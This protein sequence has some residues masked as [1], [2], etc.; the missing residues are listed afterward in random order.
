MTT[1]YTFIVGTI[2]AVLLS[3]IAYPRILNNYKADYPL[4]TFRFLVLEFLSI[5]SNLYYAYLLYQETDFMS[6]SSI[7]IFNSSLLL[8]NFYYFYC[9][10]CKKEKINYSEGCSSPLL[11]R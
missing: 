2:G 9:Y 4:N 11:K 7:I 8:A 5:S 6:V 3:I 1:T 10:F